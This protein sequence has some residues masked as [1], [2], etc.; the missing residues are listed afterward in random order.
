MVEAGEGIA[1]I[2][3]YVLPA[4]HNREVVMGRLINPVLVPG[5]IVFSCVYFF[6]TRTGSTSGMNVV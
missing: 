1:V 5:L 3:S 4:C 2:P 6:R